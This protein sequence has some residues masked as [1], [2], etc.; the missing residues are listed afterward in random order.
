MILLKLFAKYIN[1]NSLNLEQTRFVTLFKNYIIKNG[2]GVIDKSILQE[3]PFT[4]YG[5]VD[6]VFEDK[7]DIFRLIVMIINLINNN[8]WYSKTATA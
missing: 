5:G 1:E 3:A 2:V 6:K 7:L 8:G 4:N